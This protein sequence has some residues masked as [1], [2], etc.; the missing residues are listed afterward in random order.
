LTTY[1]TPTSKFIDLRKAVIQAAKDLNFSNDVQNIGNIFDKVGIVDDTVENKLPADI[2]TNPGGWGLLLCNTDPSDRNSLYKTSDYKSITPIST[3]VMYSTPSV[4]DD[5]KSTIFVDDD[6]NIR[7]LDM[8]KGKEDVINKEGDN[9][10]V[11]ISRDG[12]RIA[13]ISTYEDGRIWVF[14][15]GTGKWMAFK[16]YNPTTGSGGAKSGGPRFADAIEFNHTGEYLIYDAYNV[17]GSSLG[18]K[19]VDYW[20]IGLI[21]V[22]D[23]SRNTWG[24]G[25]VAKL[26]SDLSPGVNVFNPVFAKNSPFIIAFDFYDDED[27]N[28]TLGVNLATGEVEGIIS[29]NMPSYPSYSM[30]DKRIAFTTY[31][32]LDDDNYDV[33]YFNLESNKISAIGDPV[34]FV[35]G[36]AFPLYYGTGSR[37]LGAKPVASFSADDRSGGAPLLVKFVDA[38][39]GNP[40]SWKWTFQGGSPAS[41]TQQHPEVI[42]KTAGTYSV[43]LVATNSFGSDEVVRQ[44]YITIK[45]TFKF[46]QR[47]VAG[48]SAGVRQGIIAD[49]SIGDEITIQESVTV[50]PNPATDYAWV[51]GA[52]YEALE[53]KLFDLTGKA[54]QVKF[55]NEQEKIRVDVSGLQ[56]GIYVLYVVLENGEVVMQKIVKH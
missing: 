29:N 27:G 20:D 22:W 33:G 23:N 11:A 55:N 37:V 38:S 36:G 8:T 12:K 28:Y 47:V 7:L 34:V 19:T 49:R 4:T 53:V 25:E 17:A 24:T 18:G 50:Y 5:G 15:I 54:V 2:P 56:R 44:G 39:N 35:S 52:T 40:T 16:L 26:F 9:Q 46:G 21:N 42:Y 41:S 43:T 45:N 3:T 10:S 48:S 30:D 13:V 31:N 32:Y 1:L 51:Y 14:D 6:Y